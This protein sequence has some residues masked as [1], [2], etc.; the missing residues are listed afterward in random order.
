MAASNCQPRTAAHVEPISCTW[1]FAIAFF[2]IFNQQRSLL[3]LLWEDLLLCISSTMPTSTTLK[4]G[5]RESTH[6]AV[7]L[8]SARIRFCGSYLL[9][10]QLVPST[11]SQ[12]VIFGQLHGVGN[13]GEV[14]VAETAFV[15]QRR[16]LEVHPVGLGVAH[17]AALLEKIA[18][19]I[20]DHRDVSRLRRRGS[21]VPVRQAKVFFPGV[22]M[23]WILPTYERGAPQDE[24]AIVDNLEDQSVAFFQ[25][26][27][28]ELAVNSIFDASVY[29]CLL[30]SGCVLTQILNTHSLLVVT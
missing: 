13:F 27:T 19:H 4:I 26:E 21:L 25:A 24:C 3:G 18:A 15:R 17:K 28:P 22:I 2:I 9:L 29:A 6:L 8:R 10:L 11:D 16:N 23:L 5:G 12:L 14:V 20:P 30:R 7:A 1:A